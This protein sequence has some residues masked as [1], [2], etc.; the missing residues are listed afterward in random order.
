MIHN[1]DSF[2]LPSQ[3]QRFSESLVHSFH[4]RPQSLIQSVVWF[5][6]VAL[7]ASAVTPASSALAARTAIDD[8]RLDSGTEPIEAEKPQPEQP[9][10]GADGVEFQAVPLDASV[11]CSSVILKGTRRFQG[12][13]FVLPRFVVSM[14]KQQEPL[15]EI[16]RTN[17]DK[18][19]IRFAIFFPRT[20]EDLELRTSGSTVEMHGCNFDE[21]VAEL[22]RNVPDE[23]KKINTISRV[24]VSSIDVK[25]DG[26]AQPFTLGG[27]PSSMLNYQG[28]DQ[29]VEFAVD[30]RTELEAI[31]QRIQGDI[32]LG[33]HLQ[34]KFNAQANDGALYATVD[35]KQLSHNLGAALNGREVITPVELA[36]I[37]GT[38]LKRMSINIQTE[39]GSTNA[40][41]V[42]VEDIMKMVMGAVFT[43][44]SINPPI[45]DPYGSLGTDPDQSD[46]R[47]T[48]PPIPPLGTGEVIKVAAVLDLLSRRSSMSVSYENK[49]RSEQHVYST[50]VLFKGQ[51][52]DPDVR[53]FNIVSGEAKGRVLP[54]RITK[55]LPLTIAAI[56]SVA[57]KID[58]LP[59]TRFYS[60]KQLKTL[61]LFEFFPLLRNESLVIQDRLLHDGLAGTMKESPQWM[62]FKYTFYVWGATEYYP[63]YRSVETREFEPTSLALQNLNVF[64][65]F[66]KVGS[67]KFRLS[68][69]LQENRLWKGGFDDIGA[70]IVLLPKGN[71]GQM[72]LWNVENQG[73]VNHL[74]RFVFQERRNQRK[75]LSVERAAEEKMDVPTSRSTIKL[76]VTAGSDAGELIGLI[77]PEGN[78]DEGKPI[79]IPSLD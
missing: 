16:L 58:W 59:R 24:P 34:V 35:L 23:G 2:R 40:Y 73:K 74:R 63:V 51:L 7:L 44:G 70:K 42:M 5:L 62:P 67:R 17:A 69:L 13:A 50:S 22:N 29:I 26:V 10:R 46:G 79:L 65:Q 37:I 43:D 3:S 55:D 18:Y 78:V 49:G 11:N 21:V 32:G 76:Q 9:F 57:E 20:D 52:Q 71:L 56:A 41:A 25:I 1:R 36:G 39:T 75:T 14:N 61:K 27:G 47:P 4:W 8:L 6:A 31:L 45:E 30:N 77:S 19:I 64:V 12:T 72:T 28:G 66:S 48:A 15:F 68:D 33:I 60:T 38:Q 54:N 53:T